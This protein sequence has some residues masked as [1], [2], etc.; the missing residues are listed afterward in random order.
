MGRPKKFCHKKS[1]TCNLET[2]KKLFRERRSVLT[3]E[4]C[5]RCVEHVKRV[6]EKHIETDRIMDLNIDQLWITS[7][8]DSPSHSECNWYGSSEDKSN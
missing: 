6:E 8:G 3:S 7:G 4:F 2:V 1:T 5:G